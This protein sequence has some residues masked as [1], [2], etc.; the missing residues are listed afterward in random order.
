M[1]QKL[2]IGQ[3]MST[4]NPQITFSIIIPTL[5]EEKVLARQEAGLKSFGGETEIIVSDGGSRDGTLEIARRL[6]WSVVEG[7]RGRGSQMNAGASIARG[8]V[9][10]FLHA[11]TILPEA[12]PELISEALID[13]KVVGGNFRLKFSGN[14]RESGWLTRIYPLLRL[15]GMCYGD[16][17]FF[18]RHN[19]F[20][21]VGGFRDYPIF[22]D[23]DL[24]RRLNKVG[25]FK[26]VDG[27]A[28]TSS[29]RFEGRFMRTFL[30][31]IVLQVLYWCG[32]SPHRLAAYYRAVR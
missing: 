29:R 25:R 32:I 6:G 18:I 23:C 31:W 13:S 11:D 21:S 19:I 10:I 12:A 30:L 17:G 3:A 15:G 16:S 14:S 8:E 5:N 20:E 24:Y 2:V 27:A 4:I 22:E 28:E 7:A 1:E 26:M 9:L